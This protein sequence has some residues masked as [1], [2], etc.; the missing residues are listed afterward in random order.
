MTCTKPMVIT[1]PKNKEL[2]TVPCGM[3]IDCRLGKARSWA[4]RC[5][6]EASLHDYNSWLTLTYAR[7][8]LP[9]NGSLDKRDLTLF[10]KR[11]RKSLGTYSN[12]PLYDKA[13]RLQYYTSKAKKY[14]YRKDQPKMETLYK[15]VRYYACGEYG[16]TGTIRPHY[17]LCLFGHDWPDKYFWKFSKQGYPIYRSSALEGLWPQGFST[18]GDLTMETAGYTARYVMKKHFGPDAEFYYD[19]LEP[20]YTVMSR[21]PGIAQRW[22]EQYLTDVYPKDYFTI[23]GVKYSPPRYYDQYLEKNKPYLY[24]EIK[25]KRLAALE[26]QEEE[27]G[28]IDG[29][30]LFEKNYYREQVTRNLERTLE[31]E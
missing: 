31:N 21:R 2:V 23:E 24:A 3:C 27:N 15:E 19:G 9:E 20:E 14:A 12:M 5:M 25:D 30:R 26:K 4:I 8:H 6:H 7:E 10:I 1:N 11:L 22:I 13:M 29:K 28:M 18:I 17:H 16:R